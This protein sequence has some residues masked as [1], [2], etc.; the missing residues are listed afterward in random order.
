MLEEG[1]P[2]CPWWSLRGVGVAQIARGDWVSKRV[3]KHWDKWGAA[4]PSPLD[5]DTFMP[6]TTPPAAAAPSPPSPFR[7]HAVPSSGR[8]D[9]A[10]LL[11]QGHCARATS[12]PTTSPASSAVNSVS[13]M[14]NPA[15]LLLLSPL[16]ILR[17][18]CLWSG[19][20]W[21]KQRPGGGTNSCCS[22]PHQGG[23]AQLVS[24][25]CSIWGCT[26]PGA[27]VFALQDSSLEALHPQTNLSC[28]LHR[29]ERRGIA[30]VSA[31]ASPSR[32]QG[33]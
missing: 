31:S 4:G 14:E 22:A 8:R 30:P 15:G 28:L 5:P 3:S 24:T 27:W 17:Q 12:Q 19:A 18:L 13:G 7:G 6:R 23:G 11:A 33:N 21:L 9:R 16:G 1:H 29:S 26:W 32:L 10:L 20:T 2:A 25:K